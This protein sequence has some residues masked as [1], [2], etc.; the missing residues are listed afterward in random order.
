MINKITTLLFFLLVLCFQKPVFADNTPGWEVATIG[1]T[2]K[3]MAKSY[4]AVSD[5]NKLKKNGID[6]LIKISDEK[7]KKQYAEVYPSLVELPQPIKT[8]YGFSEK[9]TKKQAIK[10]LASLDKKQVYEIIESVPNS[11][12]AEQFNRYYSGQSKPAGSL[13]SRISELWKKL[14]LSLEGK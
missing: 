10:S 14:I 13:T 5:I 11:A 12:I 1:I 2:F 3:T 6:K 8:K 4:I 9:M 7:F